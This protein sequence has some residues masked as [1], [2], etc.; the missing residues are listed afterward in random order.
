MASARCARASTIWYSSTMKSLRRQ[1]ILVAAEAISRFGK[2]AL[3]KGLVG[4]DG[5]RGGSGALEIDGER[6]GIE[7][8]ADHPL[9]GRGFLQFGDDRRGLA[10]RLRG[11][12]V[13][14]RGE[15]AARPV[16]RD[17]AGGRARGA[18]PLR[19]GFPARI[20]SRR[21]PKGCRRMVLWF[22]YSGGFTK[23]RR[24]HV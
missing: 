17:R 24:R 14:I 5:E 15:C 20:G 8:G 18:A 22:K 1:G 13:R 21:W 10:R 19:R 4:E 11:G 3:E 9:R 12:R 16:L 2:A 7:V 23:R 6:S